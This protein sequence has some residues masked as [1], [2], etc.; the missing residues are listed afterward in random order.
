MNTLSICKEG[1]IILVHKT[2]I[3]GISDIAAPIIRALTDCYWNHCALIVDYCDDLYIAEAVANGFVPT[4]R[5][6]DYLKEVGDIREIAI[7]RIKDFDRRDFYSNLRSLI[8]KSYG[9]GTLIFT[10]LVYQISKKISKHGVWLG[11]T[12][13]DARHTVVCSEVVANA[14][15]EL[16]NYEDLYRVTPRDIWDKRTDSK[17]QIVYISNCK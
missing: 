3:Q 6:E 8:N 14:Y 7:L 1:D 17:V 15:P 9:F 13:E 11:K 5:L 12:G 4:T 16:F 2:K 10:Q